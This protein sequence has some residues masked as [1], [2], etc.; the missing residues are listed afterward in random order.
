MKILGGE[1][2]RISYN[3]LSLLLLRRDTFLLSISW[4]MLHRNWVFFSFV[5]LA[6]ADLVEFRARKAYRWVVNLC[7]G[8]HR[9]K[10]PNRM[11]ALMNDLITAKGKWWDWL[12]RARNSAA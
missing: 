10:L 7:G 1:W 9:I 3:Y 4:R 5:T 12:T 8:F 2:I 11:F 6:H